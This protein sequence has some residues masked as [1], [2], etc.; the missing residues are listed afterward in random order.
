[1]KKP[2]PWSENGAEDAPVVTAAPVRPGG[3]AGNPLTTNRRAGPWGTSFDVRPCRGVDQHALRVKPGKRRDTSHVASS[4]VERR[5]QGSLRSVALRF[6]LQRGKG[7]SS[8]S[9]CT[10]LTMQCL[11]QKPSGTEMVGEL[12]QNILL[13]CKNYRL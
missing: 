9:R 8:A 10:M 11:F 2:P 12:T 4:S 6:T 5:F 1:M 13:Y 3:Y 7:Q